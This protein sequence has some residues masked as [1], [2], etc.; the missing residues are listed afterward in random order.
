MTATKIA[1]RE[2]TAASM[3]DMQPAEFRRLVDCGAL[4]GPVMIG[5]NK[6]WRVD[7]IQAILTSAAALPSDDFEI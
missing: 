4:P 6:R 5:P 3:L 2:A 7:Q 1:V